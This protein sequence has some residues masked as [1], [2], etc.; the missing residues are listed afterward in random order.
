M[1]INFNTKQNDYMYSIMILVAQYSIMILVFYQYSIMI[2]VL[3]LSP[4]ISLTT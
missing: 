2:L 1:H 4:Q 3:R